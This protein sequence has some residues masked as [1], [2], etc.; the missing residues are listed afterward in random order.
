MTE[1][2]RLTEIKHT[3]AEIAKLLMD[4]QVGLATWHAALFR[5]VS[6]LAIQADLAETIRDKALED[7]AQAVDGRRL[8][9]GE[10]SS[11]DDLLVD[12]IAAIRALMASKSAPKMEKPPLAGTNEGSD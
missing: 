5:L 9:G 8:R 6:R 3:T 12:A 11:E 2:P 1:H 10:G 7:A 4:P